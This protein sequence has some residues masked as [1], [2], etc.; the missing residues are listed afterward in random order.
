MKYEEAISG[1]DK[2]GWKDEIENE[3]K[4]I[5]KHGMWKAVKKKTLNQGTK[6]IDSTWICKK[7]S[8]VTLR[9]RMNAICVKQVEGEMYQ[10]NSIAAPVTN[11]VT[12]CVV[13]TMMLL[14]F[15][16]GQI[17]DINGAFLHGH[18]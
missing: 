13:L 9:A 10:S 11:D 8:N 5:Q 7:K 3:H 4:R 12:I 1:P 6:V 16:H 17:V 15:W 14:S 2:Q 18:F